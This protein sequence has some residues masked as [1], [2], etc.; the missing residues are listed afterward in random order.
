MLKGSEIILDP[1][2]NTNN[3]NSYDHFFDS[4]IGDFMN[5]DT[6]QV[7]IDN[8][9]VDFNGLSYE[10]SD[11]LQ[12]KLYKVADKSLV[13]VEMNDV[14]YQKAMDKYINNSKQ[15]HDGL[16]RKYQQFDKNKNYDKALKQ[17]VFSNKTVHDIK[18][19][20]ENSKSEVMQ[21]Y[22]KLIKGGS[23]MY[24]RHFPTGLIFLQNLTFY[25][26]RKYKLNPFDAMQLATDICAYYK[27]KNENPIYHM[28]SKIFPVFKDQFLT[29]NE[30]L[31][32]E[33]IITFYNDIA[34]YIL[35][36]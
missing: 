9:D 32:V 11:D 3:D 33:N 31:K 6:K 16:I 17:Q 15:L 2:I 20:I 30:E 28:A 18:N 4:I 34:L 1:T 36:Y 29:N 14:L 7:D 10:L 25:L 21:K 12:N 26:M 22:K 8:L 24:N 5:N 13:N 19:E 35:S 27:T 23:I